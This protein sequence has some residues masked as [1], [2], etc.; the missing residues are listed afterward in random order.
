MNKVQITPNKETGAL[1]SSYTN[2]PQFGYVLL[3]QKSTSFQAGWLRE[4]VKRGIIKGDVKA[5]EGFVQDNPTLQLEGK[6]V[7]KEYVESNVPADLASQF[8]DKTL[9]YE[10]QIK[11]Y[12]KTAGE[13]GPALKS[14]NERILRFTVWDES[15]SGTDNKISHENVEEIKA[16]NAMKATSDVNLPG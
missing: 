13:G 9:S 11:T 1:V 7:V 14:D 2:N 16:F 4:V 10:K 6:L 3:T 12:I 15:G 8:F 5:L